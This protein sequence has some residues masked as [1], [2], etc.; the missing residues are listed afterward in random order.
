MKLSSKNL[1]DMSAKLSKTNA[2]K[3]KTE[4]AALEGKYAAI[5]EGAKAKVFKS[6]AFGYE[7]T[8]KLTQE[9]VKGRK[10]WDRIVVR[11]ADGSQLPFAE[12]KLIRV[13]TAAGLTNEQLETLELPEEADESGDLDQINGATVVLKLER[14]IFNGKATTEVKAVYAN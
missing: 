5:I 13:L 4:Y 1:K 2:P 6:G 12:N 9:D 7:F 14:G 3:G 11:R 8:Y 10:I